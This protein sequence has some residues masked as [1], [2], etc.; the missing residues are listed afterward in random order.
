MIDKAELRRLSKEAYD[1]VQ[2]L[3]HEAGCSRTLS[4]VALLA[5]D[6]LQTSD[7]ADQCHATA[8]G[9]QIQVVFL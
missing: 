3:H 2:M 9:R 5:I 8:L 1:V 7:L 4:D 6:Q